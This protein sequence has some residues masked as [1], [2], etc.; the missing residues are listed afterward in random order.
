MNGLIHINM[1]QKTHYIQMAMRQS[2]KHIRIYGIGF[3][4]VL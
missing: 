1:Y 4:H 2:L 3:L